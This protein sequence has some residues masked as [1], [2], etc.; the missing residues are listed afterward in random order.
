[1][2]DCK[3]IEAAISGLFDDHEI[4]YLKEKNRKIES[5]G[6]ELYG[7]E[8]KEEEGVAARGIKDN[9][10][11]FAYTYEQGEEGAESLVRNLTQLMPF[12]VHDED[13]DFP[14]RY[15][16]Y[17]DADLYDDKGA[18]NSDK[19]ETLFK[20]E[21][22]ILD[23]DKRIVA[24]RNCELHEIE[25]EARILNSKGLAFEGKKT[26]YILTGMC[27]AKDEDE[28]SWYDWSWSNHWG[29]I[30]GEKLGRRIAQ[31]T[32][33]F[34][35]GRQLE[36]GTYEGILTPQA[37]C[38]LL[39]ILSS[40]FLAEN[41]YKNKTRLK[42][43]VGEKCFADVVNIVDSGLAGTG[44]F[45]FDG[46]GVPARDNVVV[47]NGS[48]QGFLYDSYYGRK[49]GV[50]STG[51]GTRTGIKEPPKCGPRGIFIERGAA[52]ILSS[53]T[54][55]IVVEELMGTHTANPVT[56]DFSLGAIGHLYKGG[57]SMPFK[58]VIFSGNIFQLLNNVKA[59]GTDMMFYGTYGS[60]SLFVEDI[61][62]SG[63]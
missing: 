30:D 48:F 36:T 24:T 22:A 45:Y 57:T 3:K 61:R 40:S 62:I 52:D 16:T 43:R 31:K 49:F 4:Y 14:M 1:M 11:T 44:G 51:N 42:D 39:S 35:S 55:G 59:V 54:N 50:P 12:A 18:G 19:K 2:V 17:P 28:V 7:L 53:F 33:S 63:K 23:Y 56:G 10:M 20:M 5:R 9:R 15:E 32:L 38:D 60:P 21:K 34:L 37:S 8:V 41:L 58:G 29:E 47:K 26:L 46:E 27:V 25:I 6:K 13:Q